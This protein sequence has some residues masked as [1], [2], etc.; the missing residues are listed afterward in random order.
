MAYRTIKHFTDQQDDGHPYKEGD[1]Y[2]RAGAK[3]TKKRIAEL[4]GKNNKQ[5]TPLIE[6][7]VDFPTRAEANPEMS[8]GATGK[9]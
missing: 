6:E 1:P 4:S 9:E 7:I 2:P 8:G 5:G 3:A